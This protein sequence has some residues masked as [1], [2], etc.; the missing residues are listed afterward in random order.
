MRKISIGWRR[1]ALS[2][3]QNSKNRNNSRNKRSDYRWF[4][5]SWFYNLL[6]CG[7][8]IQLSEKVTLVQVEVDGGC[9]ALL[10]VH[11]LSILLTKSFEARLLPYSIILLMYFLKLLKYFFLLHL[12]SISFFIYI[13]SSIFQLDQGNNALSFLERLVWFNFAYRWDIQL[14]TNF[15][16]VSIDIVLTLYI[17]QKLLD[18]C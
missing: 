11:S 2:I 7:S 10:F 3:R 13:R 12:N 9:L 16:L 8:C 17:Y 4:G 1:K 5:L 15:R 6:A 14:V 18:R